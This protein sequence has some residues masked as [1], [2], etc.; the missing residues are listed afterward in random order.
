MNMDNVNMGSVNSVK[1]LGDRILV[2]PIKEV[3]NKTKS[4]LLLGEAVS[5]ESVIGEIVSVGPG[6]KDMIVD[7]ALKKG[8]KVLFVKYAAQSVNLDGEE[9]LVLRMDDISVVLS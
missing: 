7:E 6:K 8:A 9:Y 4:G 1:V 3:E 2:K 5:Q